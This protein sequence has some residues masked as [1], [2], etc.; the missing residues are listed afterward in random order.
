MFCCYLIAGHNIISGRNIKVSTINLI[1][2][3]FFFLKMGKGSTG[4]SWSFVHRVQ[5]R[6]GG[7]PLQYQGLKT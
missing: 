2:R 6:D 4:Y 1:V 5:S 7:A 3:S